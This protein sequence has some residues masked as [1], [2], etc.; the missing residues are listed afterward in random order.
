MYNVNAH[1]TLEFSFLQNQERFIDKFQFLIVK[2]VLEKW[3]YFKLT[4]WSS[5]SKFAYLF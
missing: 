5:A 1:F 2:R 3:K 4:V